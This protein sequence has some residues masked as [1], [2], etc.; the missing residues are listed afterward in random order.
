MEKIDEIKCQIHDLLAEKDIG[1]EEYMA[2][3]DGL[4]SFILEKSHAGKAFKRNQMRGELIMK[5]KKDYYERRF[6][7]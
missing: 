1:D 2:V 6:G 5:I 3:I 4:S 7:N